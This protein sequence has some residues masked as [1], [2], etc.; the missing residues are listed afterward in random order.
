V[1]ELPRRNRGFALLWS[2]GLISWLG[3]WVLIVALP[4]YVYER[5]G[6]ALATG[7]MFVVQALPALLLGSVAGVFV[8]RWD[9]KRVMVLS[10]LLR[11]L[12]LLPLLLVPSTDAI[13]I[14]YV[15]GFLGECVARFAEPAFNAAL[16]VV[17]GEE[18]LVEANSLWQLG[19]NGARLVGPPLGGALVALFGLEAAVL[20]DSASFFVSGALV[21]ALALPRGAARPAPAGPA[22]PTHREAALGQ[23][24][25]VFSDW[26]AGLRLVRR[27]P[28]VSALFLVIA[29]N[30]V[31]EGVLSIAYPVWVYELLGGGA[32]EVGWLLSA[33]ALGS[34]AGA[35]L[36][37]R[38]A[39]LLPPGRLMGVCGIVLGSYW[40]A[41]VLLRPTLEVAILLMA[42]IGIPLI[43]G[44]VAINSLLQGGVHDAYRG[45]VFGALATTIAVMGLLGRAFATLL[46]DALGVT[47]LLAIVAT[48]DALA[49]LAA[50][51]LLRAGVPRSRPEA[52]LAG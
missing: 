14:V 28:L 40:A 18:R 51:V 4:I 47:A 29:V 22:E 9:R 46:G 15:V 45:R 10:D 52:A 19:A 26:L 49:G 32:R 25:A 42:V 21:A 20:L 17:V 44:S 6:S 33:Q 12:F 7:T 2:A 48:F 31:A 5:T 11:G 34:I 37:G 3:N 35:L 36:V 23:L 50:L 1:L 30:M 41:M 16:P 8:D 27:S 13:W 38:F 43:G 39:G 24:R